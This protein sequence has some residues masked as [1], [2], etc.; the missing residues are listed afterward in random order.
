MPDQVGR[1]AD[2]CD[3]YLVGLAR[4]AAADFLVSGAR[5]LTPRFDSVPSALRHGSSATAARI[6]LL[7]PLWGFCCILGIMRQMWAR[8]FLPPTSK[9]DGRL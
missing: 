6:E 1:T 5:H 8:G 2:P 7:R 9:H 3:D 4:V